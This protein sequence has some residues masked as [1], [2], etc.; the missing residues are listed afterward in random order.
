MA[1]V[2]PEATAWRNLADGSDLTF[3]SWDAQSN[4]LSR[5]L[6]AHGLGR[7]DRVVIAIGPEEPFPGSSPTPPSTVSAPSPFRSTPGWPDR[8][9]V[10]SSPMPSPPRS[11]PVPPPKAAFRGATWSARWHGNRV[12]A[13]TGGGGG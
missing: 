13:T 6:A 1:D 7:G 8:N 9:S 10:P 5:G 4:R 3:R 11:S 2:H 12:L